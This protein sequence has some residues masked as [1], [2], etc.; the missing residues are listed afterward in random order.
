VCPTCQGEKERERRRAER[1]LKW[2][3]LGR[4]LVGPRG[5]LAVRLVWFL[6]FSFSFQILFQTF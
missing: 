5:G 6:F 1:A 2:A 3:G 4:K